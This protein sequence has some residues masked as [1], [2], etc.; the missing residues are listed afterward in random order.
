[1]S[2]TMIL[3]GIKNLCVNQ[4]RMIVQGMVNDRLYIRNA[5]LGLRTDP[6]FLQYHIG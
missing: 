6:T 3:R 1:M 4:M 2:H 5:G